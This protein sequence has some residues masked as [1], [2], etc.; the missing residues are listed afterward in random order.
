MGKFFQRIPITTRITSVAILGTAIAAI[1]VGIIAS[2]VVSS[3]WRQRTVTRHETN[4]A[5]VLDYL[6]PSRGAFSITDGKLLGGDFDIETNGNIVLDRLRDRMGGV[7]VSVFRGDLRIATTVIDKEGKRAIGSRFTKGAIYDTVY[8]KGVRYTGDAVVLGIPFLLA[9]EPLRDSSG[10]IIGALGVGMPMNDYYDTINGL[11]LRTALAT[12]VVILLLSVP[13]YLF[14]ANGMAPLRRLSATIAEMARGNLEVAVSD[15]SCNDDIGQIARS[16]DNLRQSL[17]VGREAESRHQASERERDQKRQ[18]IDTVT[19]SFVKRIDGMVSVFDTA[20]ARMR[21][22]AEGLNEL[23]DHTVSRVA[24]SVA[25]VEQSSSNMQTVATAAE[26][27]TA[28]IGEINRQV[29]TS[30]EYIERAKSEANHTSDMVRGLAASVA[31][32]GDVVKLINDIAAQTNLLALNATIEAA[33]AGDAGKGFAVVAG[34]VKNLANQTGKAT[35][36]IQQQIANVQ[37]ETD[38]TVGAIMQI[39]GMINEIHGTTSAMVSGVHQQKAATEEIVASVHSASESARVTATNVAGVK[40]D[41]ES[42]GKGAGEVLRAAQDLLAQSNGLHRE[43]SDFV[44]Q[45]RA[46]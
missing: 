6:N 37:S 9:Y 36:D 29:T 10:T 16:I 13:T 44:R 3:D 45:V 23:A 43:I 2:L 5:I 8:T 4:L 27:L 40:R 42:A 32:I 33:R 17:A 39:L 19:E 1:A 20:A 14:V 22:N 46:D 18:R 24:E 30:A 34:E 25:A 7:V 38:R 31:R 11:Y 12:L 41:S 21:G 15:T 35:D 26:E 28:S